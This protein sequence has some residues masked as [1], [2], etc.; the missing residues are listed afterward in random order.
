M[1]T[2][3]EQ[4]AKRAMRAGLINEDEAHALI[5]ATRI[6]L[7]TSRKNKRSCERAYGTIT[8]KNIGNLT[9]DIDPAWEPYIG[10]HMG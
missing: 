10:S 1:I 3:V 5:V 7:H 2:K 4:I 9:R 6:A 8:I